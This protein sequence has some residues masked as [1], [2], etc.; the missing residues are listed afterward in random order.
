MLKWNLLLIPRF[1]DIGCSNYCFNE[2]THS[3]CKI[4]ENGNPKCICWD[5]LEHHELYKG[6]RCEIKGTE[7]A[8]PHIRTEID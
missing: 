7:I 4:D 8:F 6:N 5:N 1:L 2:G 3:T